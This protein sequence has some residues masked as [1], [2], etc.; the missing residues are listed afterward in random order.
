MTGHRHTITFETKCYENDWEYVLRTNRLKKAIDR[1]GYPFD[2]R[3][4]YINNVENPEKVGAYAERLVRTGVIDN[5]VYVSNHADEALDHFGCS[6]ENLGR[7]YY[8]SIAEMVGI[9]LCE[10]DYLLHFS[11]DSIMANH[12]EWIGSAIARMERDDRIIAANPAYNMKFH[13]G[14]EGSVAEDEFFYVGNL[15]SDRCYLIAP[16]RFRGPIYNERNV[17]SDKFFPDHGGESFEKRIGA[18]MQNH[19]YLRLTSKKASYR[20]ENFSKN[21]LKRKAAVCLAWMGS[22]LGK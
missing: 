18:Y 16:S 1:C 11:S 7:G 4:L 13:R 14:K 3:V 6:R 10:T 19:G 9:Y 12:E 21:R 15:F 22:H 20:H 8:Y 5:F 17:L 2:R